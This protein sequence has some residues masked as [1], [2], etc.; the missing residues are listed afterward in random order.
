ML[1]ETEGE[2]EG[3]EGFYGRGRDGRS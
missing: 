2:A 3:G 1:L